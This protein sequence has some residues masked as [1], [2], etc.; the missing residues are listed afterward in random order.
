M[1][2]RGAGGTPGGIGTFVIGLCMLVAG[3]F[4]LL[5]QVTVTTGFWRLWGYDASGLALVPLLVGVGILFFNGRSPLGWLLVVT[6]AITVVA[7]ILVHLRFY[8]RPA[9]LFNTLMML[10]LI[11][12]GIG[13]V[14][15]SLREYPPRDRPLA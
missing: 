7:G 11:A 5:N 8:F 3:A 15:R 9:S 13:V 12:G 10:G 4:L 2:I 14:A 6:G 1:A